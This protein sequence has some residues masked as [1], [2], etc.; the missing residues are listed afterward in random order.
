MDAARSCGSLRSATIPHLLARKY[1]DRKESSGACSRMGRPTARY[2][3]VFPGADVRMTS[4][5]G[6]SNARAGK[7]CPPAG[8]WKPLRIGG[9]AGDG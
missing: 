8:G 4:R 5:I 1:Q 3:P 6:E 2:S 9:R 7:G